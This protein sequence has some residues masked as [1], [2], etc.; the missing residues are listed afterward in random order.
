MK[1]LIIGI[2]VVFLGILALAW[3]LSVRA[4]PVFL[5][6]SGRPVNAPAGRVS[7]VAKPA[8]APTPVPASVT[9]GLHGHAH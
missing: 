2:H 1:G 4:H 9:M 6:E 8:A 3:A 7:V 5:D